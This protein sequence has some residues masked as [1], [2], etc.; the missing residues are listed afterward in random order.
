M[1]S[2]SLGFESAIARIQSLLD[3]N[4]TSEALVTSVFTAEKTLRRTF[5]TVDGVQWLHLHPR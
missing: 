1:Y 4:F 3:S 5:A 2:V